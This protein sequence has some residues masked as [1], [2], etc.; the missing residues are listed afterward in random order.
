MYMQTPTLQH[1]P[2]ADGDGT[3]EQPGPYAPPPE[4]LEH[5]KG[6]PVGSLSDP[7]QYV[8]KLYAPCQFEYRVYVP[9]Q[10]SPE[11]PA[12]LM[13]FQDGSLYVGNDETKFNTATVFDNLIHARQMPVTLGLFI[14]PG[15]PGPEQEGAKHENR[16]DQYDV[17]DDKY[18]RF[19]LDE[20]IPDVVTGNYRIVADPEGWAITG[21][22]SGGICAFTV[23][24]HRPDKFRKV[25]THNGSFTNIKGGHVYPELVRKTPAKPLR[26]SLLS[27]TKDLAD[28]RGSWMQSNA[29]LARAL[30]EKGYH[31]R[32]RP[33]EGGH[34]PPVQA[35]ADYVDS[36]RWLW[37]GYNG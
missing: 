7:A 19:L 10:Y 5:L 22:S 4:A 23:A 8:S 6:A 37:R 29:D 30:G 20:I 26:V 14:N 35:V 28:E 24:W 17:L 27:G 1:D 33:G 25:L 15:K 18:T 21:F 32:H 13:V 16:S 3:T 36:L 12:A 34:Y 9:A 11:K 2:G 31:C